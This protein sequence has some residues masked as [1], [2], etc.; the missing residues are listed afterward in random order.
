MRTIYRRGH[1]WF[2]VR[3]GEECNIRIRVCLFCR[4]VRLS[5]GDSPAATVCE[6]C[7]AYPFPELAIAAPPATGDAGGAHSGEER[8]R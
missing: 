3:C 7:G 6:S 4:R 8:G 2:R 1:R 5:D